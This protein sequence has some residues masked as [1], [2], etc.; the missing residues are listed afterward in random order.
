[1][2]EDVLGITGI[3]DLDNI[4]KTFDEL[5]GKLDK[6]GVKTDELSNQ[7]T[8]AL[9]RINA[10]NA[11]MA[12]KQKQSMDVLK[13]GIEQ[14]REL[15]K[16]LP[17]A[18]K[19]AG[20]ET[21]RYRQTCDKLRTELSSTVVGSKEFTDI[22]DRLRNNEESMQRAS[23]R[24]HE[25]SQSYSEVTQFIAQA[26]SSIDAFNGISSTATAATG[27]NATAHGAAAVAVGAEAAQHTA[28]AEE[29]KKEANAV[30]ENKEAKS[31]IVE[32][33]QQELNLF[34][35]EAQA[36]DEVTNKIK[37]GTATQGEIAST[38]DYAQQKVE[39]LKKEYDALGNQVEAALQKMRNAESKVTYGDDGKSF[40]IDDSE[41]EKAL[42]NYNT[43]QER[44]AQMG[45][46]L[47]LLTKAYESLRATQ[48]QSVEKTV[49]QQQA[50]EQAAKAEKEETDKIK[51]KEVEI[52]K[53]IQRL[54]ELKAKQK[55]ARTDETTGITMPN[56]LV[57]LNPNGIF[58]D[59]DRERVMQ[60]NEEIATTK[61]RIASAKDELDA[62]REKLQQ[63]KE[64]TQEL[65]STSAAASDPF[66]V[67]GASASELKERISECGNRLKELEAEYDKFANKENLTKSQQEHFNKLSESIRKYREEQEACRQQLDEISS[68][69][70]KAKAKMGEYGGKLVDIMT[71]HGNF[72][73]SLGDV[74]KAFGSLG[75]PIKG[76]V[77]GVVSMTRALWAMCA[78]PIGA[79]IAAVVLGLQA[80]TTWFRKSAEGQKAFSQISAFVGS[81]LSSLT[82]ILVKV[83][84]YLY[85]AFADAQGPM[86]SFANG[87]VTTLKS[88]VKTASDLL[89]GL[90]DMVRGV[91]T[92]FS[93]DFDAAWDYIKNGG[94]KI[95]DGLF[96]AV[97]TVGD[98]FVT[99]GKGLMGSIQMIGDGVSGVFNANL[100]DGLGNTV[101][102]AKQA[103]D[104][105]RQEFENTLAAAQAREHAARLEKEIAENREKIYTLSG[106]EK[107][108]LIERTK[109]LEKQKY[110]GWDDADGNHHAGLLD[111]QR[112]QLEIQ[113]QRN[114][115]HEVTLEDL[116]KEREL[117]LQI[118]NTETQQAAST[119]MLTRMEAANKRSM[120]QQDKQSAQKDAKQTAAVNAANAKLG[121]TIYVNE[122][123]RVKQEK[124]MEQRI[125]EARV[126]AM[127][128]GFERTAA[129]REREQQEELDKI[130]QQRLAAL[131]AE[132]KRQKA[133]H[134]AQQAVI[135]AGGGKVTEWDNSMFQE[136]DDVKQINSQYA[137][138]RNLTLQKQ[139]QDE[140]DAEDELIKTYQSYAD[141]KLQIEKDYQDS[142]AQINAAIAE[143]E[144]RGDTQRVEALKRS[145]LEAAKQRNEN[146]A[147][148]SLQ[149][150]RESPDYVRAFEDLSNTSSETLQFLIQKFEEAKEAAAQSL[151]PEKL[152]EYTS[153]LQQMYDELNS[154]DPF[155]ALKNSAQELANAEIKLKIASAAVAGA[156]EKV[157]LARLTGDIRQQ[158]EAM[159]E[160]AD[161]E[162]K[163]REAT[164]NVEKA[165]N[166]QRKAFK[167]VKGEVD[168]LASAIAGLGDAIGGE[169]GQ[170]L[171]IISSVMTFT[172][173]TIDG[174]K[175]VT[176]TGV[177]ALSTLEKASVILTIISAAIQ[178]FQKISSMYK[179]AHAQY[180]DFAEKQREINTLR[181]AVNDYRL[182]VIEATNAEKR[183]FA[184]TGLDSLKDMYEYSNAALEAY[185]EKMYEAQAIYQNESGGGWLTNALSWLGNLVSDIVSLP[186]K[187]ITGA[188][189]KMGIL[190]KDSLL[191]QIMDWGI[192]GLFGGVEGLV[193]KGVGALLD[194]L[195]Y[196]E[197][198]TAAINNLR[199]ETRKKSSGFLGSGIGGHSQKTEDLRTWVKDN[200]GEDLFGSDGFINVNL[201]NTVLDKYGDKLVGET[202]AT[203]E[204]L[205]RLKEEYDKFREQLEDYVSEMFSP[206]TDDMTDSLWDWLSEGKNVMDSFK[207]YASDTFADIAKEIIKQ[208]LLAKVFDGFQ[209]K[210]ANLYEVYSMGGLTEKQLTDGIIQATD[211][212]LNNAEHQLPMIQDLLSYIDEQF[213]QRG[214][215]ITGSDSYEQSASSKAWQNMSQ[216][217]AE[218]LNGR[219][220]ALQECGL[221]ILDLN[222]ERNELLVLMQ[223]DISQTRL[224]VVTLSQNMTELV[225]VQYDSLNKLDEII[226][227]TAPLPDMAAFIEKIY[228]AVKNVNKK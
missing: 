52:V 182:A 187:L 90:G 211:A 5:I 193:G 191:G 177:A 7:M 166:K 123:A 75:A 161:A 181:D 110:E 138:L 124:E 153:T 4:E 66:G 216:D 171:G 109:L 80:L 59:E 192:T 142:V 224:A 129:E 106:K 195:N 78:T 74:G 93:G 18:I 58:N 21:E 137:Q 120:D 97:K 201:A 34:Q 194:T 203:L 104:L 35:Q 175:A 22:S 26:S 99:A 159:Q 130:E 92:A 170:I 84:G 145:L 6:V 128:Q 173:Q 190:D 183:W 73:Q 98:A 172:T 71:G 89:S 167:E 176:A 189:D 134:D 143:A 115:L 214:F 9:N 158:K 164:D 136:T 29:I 67:Q 88:A 184:S 146:Q 127:Q 68:V 24:A 23:E 42:A 222:T 2:A 46:D 218:E 154:R 226:A 219:F 19:E 126:K 118:I 49:Q 160:L 197:G 178:L 65:N 117:R 139:V 57:E 209:D 85:H 81:I 45:K 180:E 156:Q 200:L 20:D 17:S 199:I 27:V 86:N 150:L 151:D 149:V 205:I 162:Q 196:K 31:G 107:Q 114:S 39:T 202:K 207:K 213:K 116:A 77:G 3:V 185:I 47:E 61:E 179:D 206:L 135:K 33:V 11:D 63:A 38:L 14:A 76:A 91:I 212:L 144:K 198:T 132:R 165:K 188:L 131:E 37:A 12:T 8:Q 113:K 215:D 133:E 210:L 228:N 96:G 102:K 1:M 53:L 55:D 112:K 141:K 43:L 13:G 101:S 30:N 108:D 122:E 174:I 69:W 204:E 157:R 125:A 152:R 223:A 148:V 32:V 168:Q 121:E 111:T 16:S 70:D 208:A 36:I 56:W 28:N 227:N 72:Q 225:D 48:E 103:A 60:L 25:L 155:T 140:R 54:D 217:T 82:D 41:I 186:G 64:K 50:N 94:L 79:I 10:S 95:A 87:L 100:A 83:G 163:E 105:T 119:R 51:Q 147:N 62:M 44:Y 221:R 169:A 40:T 220:T 15:L